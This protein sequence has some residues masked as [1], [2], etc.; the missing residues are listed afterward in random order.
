MK[1]LWEAII[2]GY[3]KVIAPVADWMVRKRINPNTITTVGTICSVIAGA[4]FAAGHIRTAGWVLGLTALFDVLDGTVARRTGRSTVFGAFYDSTLDR[5]ADGALLGGLTIFFAR[6]DVHQAIPHSMGTPMVAVLILGSIG[7]FLTSY[8]RARAESL[9]IDA[10]V[11]MLQRPERV[12]LLSAP[13]AFFGLALNG[14]V[15]ITICVLLS[16]TAWITAVQRILYVYRVTNTPALD[17]EVAPS[18]PVAP[19]AGA[20]A[21]RPAPAGQGA[22]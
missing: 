22:R 18:A 7:T 14:W 20:E 17:A 5:V 8:T 15:L 10:K 9:G 21:R 1:S 13:Q 4:I 16:V 11:G 2:R 6:N 3:L 12:T 19:T